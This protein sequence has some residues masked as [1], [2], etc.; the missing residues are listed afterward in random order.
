MEPLQP[1]LR[2]ALKRAHP[3]LTDDAIDQYEELLA[4]RYELDPETEVEQIRR[5]DAERAA[6]VRRLMPR[7]EEVARAFGTG[8]FRPKKRP[9]P[10]IRFKKTRPRREE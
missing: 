3:G 6:L 5:L 2:E 9:P 1:E 10:N 4:R 8:P 7:Y